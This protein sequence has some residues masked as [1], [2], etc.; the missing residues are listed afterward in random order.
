MTLQGDSSAWQSREI[1]VHGAASEVEGTAQS[2]P[3]RNNAIHVSVKELKPH[4]LL[5]QKVAGIS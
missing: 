2:S 4:E 1:R 3:S 5:L